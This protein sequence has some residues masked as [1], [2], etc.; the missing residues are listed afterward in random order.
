LRGRQ[1][2]VVL[3]EPEVKIAVWIKSKDWFPKEALQTIEELVDL[4]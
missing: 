3:S 4:W 2:V 1:E